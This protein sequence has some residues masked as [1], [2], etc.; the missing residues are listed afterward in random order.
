[1]IL[2]VA[3]CSFSCFFKCVYTCLVASLIL[4][5]RACMYVSLAFR[6]G[7]QCVGVETHPGA[8]GLRKI[9]RV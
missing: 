2:L 6:R 3:I 1:M 9:R 5:S 4:L 7:M 8:G